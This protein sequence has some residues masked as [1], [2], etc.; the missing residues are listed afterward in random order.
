MNMRVL[1]SAAFAAA[2]F[3]ACG[4]GG[5]G[6]S[7]VATTPLATPSAPSVSGDM[8]AAVASKGWNYSGTITGQNTAFTLYADPQTTNVIT[9]VGITA[10]STNASA[11][12]AF[13]GGHGTKQGGVGLTSSAAGYNAA[14]FVLLFSNG[15]IFSQGAVPM[16]SLLV[17]STLTLNSTFATYPGVSAT[18]TFVGTVPGASACPTPATGATVTYVFQGQTTTISYVPGCGITALTT[19][20]V[21]LTLTSVSS[22]PQ[23]GTLAGNR[24]ADSTLWDTAR[25][26]LNVVTNGVNWRF[27]RNQAP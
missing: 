25:S 18:V 27:G 4:G 24:L 26:V 22:Y 2:F 14:A 12:T 10:A 9:L 8:I 21:N 5:G 1:F 13:A 17:P 7:T 3:S 19:N 6:S 15:Q 11:A 16:T 20:G 23:L